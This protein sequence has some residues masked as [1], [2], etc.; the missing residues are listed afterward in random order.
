[1][2]VLGIGN[3]GL[4][5]FLHVLCDPL[6]GERQVREGLVHLFATDHTGEQV[7]FLRRRLQHAQLCTCF[8]VCHAA[9]I[10]ILAHDLFPLRFFISRMAII[11]PSW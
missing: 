9:G 4:K 8:V 2:V 7:K 5:A 11:S 6:F 3:R 10:F 1:M